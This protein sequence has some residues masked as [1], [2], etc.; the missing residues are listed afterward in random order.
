LKQADA[1]LFPP[2]VQSAKGNSSTEAP[3]ATVAQPPAQSSLKQHFDR[4]EKAAV[5]QPPTQKS[6]KQH[7]DC[8]EGN[9]EKLESRF[10][11]KLSTDIL[12]PL[13]RDL[14]LLK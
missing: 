1:K 7:L 9:F 6:L 12:S 3:Q 11:K 5:K 14:A 8:L 10:Y 13:N 4:L 2:A